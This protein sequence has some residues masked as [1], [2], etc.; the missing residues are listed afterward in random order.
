MVDLDPTTSASQTAM[1][2]GG[3][4]MVFNATF[5]NIPIKL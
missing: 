4:G 5:Y 1:G 2:G 3:G